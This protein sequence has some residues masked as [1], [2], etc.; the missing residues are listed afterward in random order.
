[1][2]QFV[3]VVLLV[4]G[5]CVAV[6]AAYFTTTAAPSEGQARVISSVSLYRHSDHTPILLEVPSNTGDFTLQAPIGM[7]IVDQWGNVLWEADPEQV[8]ILKDWE[9]LLNFGLTFEDEDG[10]E[11]TFSGKSARRE[12]LRHVRRNVVGF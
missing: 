11:H 8:E 12:I 4:A 5:L 10:E 7:R 6:G 1:M 3:R 2:N 9:Y